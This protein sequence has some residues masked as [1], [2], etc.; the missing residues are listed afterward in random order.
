MF[1]NNKHSKP[2]NI[3]SQQ[4]PNRYLYTLQLS[5]LP[6]KTISIINNTKSLVTTTHLDETSQSEKSAQLNAQ[7]NRGASIASSC[8]SLDAVLGA[9][10]QALWNVKQT[11]KGDGGFGY[12]VSVGKISPQRHESFRIRTSNCFLH[13]VF[14]GFLIEIEYLEHSE[15][16]N[17]DKSSIIHL[18]S[19]QIGMIKKLIEV[20]KFPEGQLCFNVLSDSK[21]DYL[22]DLCQQYSDALQF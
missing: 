6:C 22:S 2:S 16:V 15:D 5:Y 17:E 20:F 19:K 10:F 13:G 18:F 3:H 14:K 7:F 8:N 12:E 11:I 9:R 4:V 1:L 21:L